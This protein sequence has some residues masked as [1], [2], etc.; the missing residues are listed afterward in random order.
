M[1]REEYLKKVKDLIGE[2]PKFK[3]L[4]LFCESDEDNEKNKDGEDS[5]SE[6]EKETEKSLKVI[7]KYKKLDKEWRDNH[8]REEELEDK[9][10]K[11]NQERITCRKK[12]YND[13][14][15]L[16][17]KEQFKVEN[18]LKQLNSEYK[19]IVE[20]ISLR[21]EFLE[22]DD[23]YMKGEMKTV[24]DE[25]NKLT[26]EKNK[27]IEKGSETIKIQCRCNNCVPSCYYGSNCISSEIISLEKRIKDI[28]E[29]CIKICDK[30]GFAMELIYQER[31]LPYYQKYAKEFLPE[32]KINEEVDDPI[33]IFRECNI[34]HQWQLRK[35]Y[36]VSV[37]NDYCSE[38]SD[39]S[40]HC[41]GWY[42]GNNRC[43]CGSVK[44]IWSQDDFKPE[45]LISFSIFETIPSGHP[46]KY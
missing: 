32:L 22:E 39:P 3:D 5:D 36:L 14:L 12:E 20:R 19:K 46:E 4:Y 24:A 35:G 7:E 37:N 9:I 21:R 16:I 15:K 42:V 41:I 40:N 1:N 8:K 29:T 43:E 26:G 28:K 38:S 13:A 31:L 34:H 2:K 11:L 10:R 27:L 33:K 44:W 17:D 6:F 25:I 23:N 18:K 30:T 45:E